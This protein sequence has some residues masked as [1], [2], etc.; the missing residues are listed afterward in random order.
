LRMETVSISGAKVEEVSL[1]E[2][3]IEVV[4]GQ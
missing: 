1:E 2:E 4:D 3:E